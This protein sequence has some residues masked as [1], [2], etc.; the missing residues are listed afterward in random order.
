M[1]HPEPPEDKASA[2]DEELDEATVDPP[3]EAGDSGDGGEKP[4]SKW[5]G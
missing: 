4:E 3:A 5:G 2:V 1:G